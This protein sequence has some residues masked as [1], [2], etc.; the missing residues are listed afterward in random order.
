MK[1][2]LAVCG[3]A[4]MVA[5]FAT[6]A[7]AATVSWDAVTSYTDNSVMTA[8]EAAAVTYTL[9]TADTLTGIKSVIQANIVGTSVS[10]TQVTRGKYY[11]LTA[12]VNGLVSDYSPG[13]LYPLGKPGKPGNL[14][15]NQQ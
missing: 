15:F 2:S 4:L 6:L 5:A 14:R 7:I 3:G 12:A 10:S 13:E 1:K 8:S 11:F 9:H